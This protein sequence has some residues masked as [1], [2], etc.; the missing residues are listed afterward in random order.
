MYKFQARASCFDYICARL[1]KGLSKH[2]FPWNQTGIHPVYLYS[3][4][5]MY[6]LRSQDCS[7]TL[8]IHVLVPTGSESIGTAHLVSVLL[9]QPTCCIAKLLHQQKASL[10]RVEEEVRERMLYSPKTMQGS[11]RSPNSAQLFEAKGETYCPFL[12]FHTLFA[13]SHPLHCLA[14][15]AVMKPK[16][17]SNGLGA[18]L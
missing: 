17:R 9:Q 2:H 12:H 4:S 10:P 13:L 16:H 14:P 18:W 3:D 5:N 15:V 8:H 1:Y 11:R 7:L 6:S